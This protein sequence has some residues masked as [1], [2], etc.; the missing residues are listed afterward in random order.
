MAAESGVTVAPSRPVTSHEVAR[1][2]GVSQPTVSRALRDEPGVSVATRRKVRDAARALGYTPQQSGRSLSTRTTG[3]AGIVAAE[4]GNPFYPVLVGAL[5][6][7]LERANYGTILVTDR[8]QAPHE[9]EALLDGSLDGVVL[10]T[11]ETSS[12]LPAEL[13]SRGFPFVL[14]NREVD[15]ADADACV[16][17]NR[18][19]ARA[20]A[21]LLAD[22]GHRTIAAVM[23]PASTTTGREREESFRDALSERGLTLPPRFVRRGPFSPET[24]YQALSEL[25]TLTPAPTAV[26]C[27]NDVIA[28]GLCNA[29]RALGV[30]IP[31]ELS[32]IGFDDIP[33]AKWE[34]FELTTVRCDLEHMATAAVDLLLRRIADPQA[35]PT[36]VVLPTWLVL[37]GTHARV[38]VPS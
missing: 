29:A 8:G 36:R 2:A 4:L 14:L 20:V 9:M 25:L 33:M 11:C 10:T 30:R 18:S 34:V 37:R 26:F 12:P 38:K 27:G 15:G 13:R 24:G 31:Q 35:E 3:R 22:L 7:A 16:A 19:G 32:V 1:L 5:H 23:G 6:D 17:D 28:L 21:D